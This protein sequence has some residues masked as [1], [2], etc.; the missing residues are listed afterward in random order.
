[1][2][3]CKRDTTDPLARALIKQGIN[4]ILPPR[5]GVA[6]GDLILGERSGSVRI[7]D[8]R[9]VMGVDPHPVAR[10]EPT[11]DG[12]SFVVSRDM[13]AVAGVS[14]L[15]RVLGTLG[16][17]PGG[18]SSAF[19]ASGAKNLNIELSSPAVSAVNNIDEILQ[20]LRHAGARPQPAYAGRRAFVV[21]RAWRARGLSLEMRSEAGS[22]VTLGA[23]AQLA[24]KA[25]A[26]MAIL[27]RGDGRMTFAALRPLVFGVTLRELLFDGPGVRDASVQ[28][29]VVFRSLH[30]AE[31]PHV[32]ASDD[33][34]F[35]DVGPS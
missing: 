8:W 25:E 30:D 12:V 17:Q 32:F 35:V 27:D 24:L 4:I 29:H 18:L 2:V 31:H 7:A 3:A 21:E 15:G 9:I 5:D 6:P 19:K 13:S 1:M 23:E 11:F 10:P 16:L 28:E 34:L 14:V 26:Q 22:R 33:D 20:T